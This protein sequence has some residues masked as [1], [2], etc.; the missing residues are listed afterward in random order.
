MDTLSVNPAHQ[1]VLLEETVNAVLQSPEGVYMDLTFGR[2]G[3]TRALLE[4]LSPAGRLIA[5]DRDE[6]AIRAGESLADPRLILVHSPFS[7]LSE[8][9]AQLH[10]PPVEGILADLGVSSPQLDVAER[11]FSFMRDGPLDM[12]MDPASGVPASEWLTHQS[13]A[14]LTEVLDEFGE[15]RHA[16]AVAQAICDHMAA[17]ERGEAEP[18]TRTLQLAE[19]VSAVVRRRSRGQTGGIHPA[20]RSFQAI[21]IAVNQELSELDSLLEAAPRV[22]RPNGRLAVI[23]F[24]SLEDRRVKKAFRP[25]APGA[26]DRPRGMGARQFALLADAQLASATA[27]SE[28]QLREV[29]RIM[30]SE[31]EADRNP[32]ARSAVLRVAVCEVPSREGA[33]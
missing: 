33:A 16:R 30:P 8:V 28:P 9:H 22:L 12:R 11:G 7:A 1:T 6:A 19:L 29:D 18:L 3:H 23:S 20:T 27:H 14:S 32:R 13:V 31:A 17:A 15:E 4:R 25:R 21:R 24:H 2:G 26:V 10:L 5:F